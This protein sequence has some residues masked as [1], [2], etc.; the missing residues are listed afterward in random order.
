MVNEGESEDEDRTIA[1]EV[2]G[3]DEPD[4]DEPIDGASGAVADGVVTVQ[5]TARMSK[6]HTYPSVIRIF[7]NIKNYCYLKNT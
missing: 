6:S 2:G 7:K 1:I 3:T 5:P 4:I